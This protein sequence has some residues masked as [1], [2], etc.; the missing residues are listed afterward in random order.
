[1]VKSARSKRSPKQAAVAG[2]L[3]RE[4]DAARSSGNRRLR[5]SVAGVGGRRLVRWLWKVR[6]PGSTFAF[7]GL[8]FR[9]H[10]I[11]PRRRYRRKKEGGPPACR[12]WGH[13]D[14]DR[15]NINFRSID[16][17]DLHLIVVGVLMTR[18]GRSCLLVARSIERIVP[19]DGVQFPIPQMPM[20]CRCLLFPSMGFGALVKSKV[21]RLR[22]L[23]DSMT[24]WLRWRT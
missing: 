7:T 23:F 6:K 24:E 1:M 21:R 10:S 5:G 2:R 8:P 4:A 19:P 3:E 11:G 15:D 12:G 14:R 22:M 20:C 13:L 17:P 16:R 18:C 9:G